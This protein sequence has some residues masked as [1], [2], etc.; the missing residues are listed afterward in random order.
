MQA[1]VVPAVDARWKLEDVPTT[2]P[3]PN[4]VLIRIHASGLCFTDVHQTKGQLPGAFPRILGHEPVGEIV[5][6]GP[7]VRT[8]RVGDRVGVP[9]VQASCGRCEWCFRGRPMFCPNQISTAVEAPGGHAEYMPAYADATMPLPDG[10]SYEQAAPIFC[11]GYTVWSG[12]RWADPQPHERVAVVGIGGLGH[13]AVQY[14]K[15]AGFETIAISHS[16]D[17]DKMVRELGADVIVRDGKGLASAGGADVI[18]GT[19]NSNDA[20]ADAIQG[21]RPDGR[22]VLMGFEAKPLPV[23][24]GD[25]ITRRIKVVG[26]QQNGREYLYEALDY[27]AKGKVKVMAETYPLADVNKAYDRVA[28]GKARFRAVIVN[29]GL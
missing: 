9:W 16:A 27:V 11:A 28:E 25:L 3:G 23:S 21:L 4:Q 6:V 1:V 18:L 29:D 22:F 5:A 15:A 24:P 10:L 7:G 8:R 2:D 17:K 26:S 14:A 19:S 13:L 20:M 12:L